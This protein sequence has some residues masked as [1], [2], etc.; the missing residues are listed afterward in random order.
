MVR[1]ETV[2]DDPIFLDMT[3]DVV[4]DVWK[5]YESGRP[6][7]IAPFSASGASGRAAPAT[8]TLDVRRK[9]HAQHDT[10]V[11]DVVR[12][13]VVDGEIEIAADRVEAVVSF[14]WT[15]EIEDRP[16]LERSIAQ[17]LEDGLEVDAAAAEVV[18]DARDFVLLLRGRLRVAA[19]LRIGVL[20]MHQREAREVV[21]D[22]LR[23]VAASERE[24]PGVG[25]QPHVLRIGQLHHAAHFA[26]ALDRTPD[27]R[28]RR[29]PDAHRNRLPADLVQRVGEPLELIV[30]RAAGGTLPHVALPQRR[31]ER[32]QKVLA[33]TPRDPRSSSASARGR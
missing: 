28:M 19:V 24:V 17:H 5:R 29:H 30:A 26:L 9:L 12:Q 18:I 32:L 22:E 16:S 20:E 21:V 2:N 27:V 7:H 25:G 11:V 33:R 13:V 23:G 10:Q 6:L 1:A 15:V 4:L 8:R 14:P 3:A 31:A